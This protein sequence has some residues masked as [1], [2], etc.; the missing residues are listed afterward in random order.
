MPKDIFGRDY[1]FMPSAEL[2]T[3]EEITRLARIAAAHGVE[4]IRLTG[5]EPL[6]RKGLPELVR[7][8]SE[9]RTP[10]DRQLDIALTTNGSALAH[11]AGALKEAGL[12]RVTVSLD[13]LDDATFQEMNDVRF[14]V[15]KVLHGIE[16]AHEV[17][18]GPIKINMVVKRGRNDQD[19]VAMARHFR[20]T[21]YILRF[22]EFMDVGSTNGWQ[23]GEVVPS[24]EVIRRIDEVFPLEELEPNYRGETSQALALPRRAGR[25]RGDFEC[26]AVVLPL[27]FAGPHLGRR[28]ALH[29]PV[30]DRRP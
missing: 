17:G 22:I 18:L 13:S 12:R 4:K 16:V 19:I 3:F 10:D 27:L 8:L 15:E 9:L 1:A 5:G 20:G 23:L 25:D 14:P 7:M 11:L 6:L 2:L 21:P 24:A 30:R 29:L 28:N 26:H